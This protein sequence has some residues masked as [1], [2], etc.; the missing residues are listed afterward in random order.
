MTILTDDECREIYNAAMAM[1]ERSVVQTM[2]VIGA[3]VLTKLGAGYPCVLLKDGPTYTLD[4]EQ[5]KEILNSVSKA[6]HAAGVA[7]CADNAKLSGAEG[8]RS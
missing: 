5:L 3:A 2:R 6:A 7:A 4:S 8:V 1:P